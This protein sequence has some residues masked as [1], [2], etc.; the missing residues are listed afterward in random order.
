MV[1]FTG[2]CEGDHVV[3]GEDVAVLIEDNAA[4]AAGGGAA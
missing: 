1:V 4:T 3:V 2:R